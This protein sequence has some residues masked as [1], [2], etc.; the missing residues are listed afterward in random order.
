[1][2]STIINDEISELKRVL[3]TQVPDSKL[4]ACV[5]AMIR[6]EL[7]ET[8]F[9][10]VVVCMS[11]PAEYP[12]QPILLELKSK[13]LSE[14][15]ID[16]LVRVSE[17]EAKKYLGKPHVIFVVK[18]IRQFIAENPLCCC[19]GEI[20]QIKKLLRT[21]T[22]KCKLS[23]KTSSITLQINHNK[24]YLKTKLKV[25]PDYPET[26]VKLEDT[27]SNFPR[28]F[29][30]WFVEKAR[31]FARQCVEPPLKPKPRDP[32]FKKSPSLLPV[33]SFLVKHVQRY[34]DEICQVC[35]HKAFPDD[36]AEAVHNEHAAAHVE[37]VYCS[38][39]YHHDCL[40]LYLKSP[41]F[42]GVKKCPGCKLRIYHEKWKVTPELAEARWAHKQAKDRELGEV[43]DF[44]G[45]LATS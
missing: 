12:K 29:K 14:K 9:K 18:F 10:K 39:I 6:I 21:E 22:D 3:E 27:E 37:R 45:D 32:P 43:V 30:V 33:V 40:I 16:G 38:H 44:L 7:E 23:Q 25:P 8:P 11:Y 24:Y 2:A 31:E 28:V 13:T 34:P 20:T 15:L 1:M 26:Q 35:K 17:E 4:V 41:P 36:P 42:D 19:S 5:P